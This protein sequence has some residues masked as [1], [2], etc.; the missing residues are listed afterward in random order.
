MDINQIILR[1]NNIKNEVNKELALNAGVA[2]ML[3]LLGTFTN[4]IF[5]HGKDANGKD[6]SPYSTKPSYYSKNSFVKKGAFKGKGKVKAKT[7]TMYLERGYEEFKTIQ[8]RPNKKNFELTGSLRGSIQVGVS[9]NELNLG[10]TDSD[11]STKASWLEKNE[12]KSV[13]SVSNSEK[14]KLVKDITSEVAKQIKK[15]FK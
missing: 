6:L 7:K 9:N 11:E 5:K 1:L 3:N 8:G 2:P 14:D 15:L 10:Y 13:F 12:G 4:R